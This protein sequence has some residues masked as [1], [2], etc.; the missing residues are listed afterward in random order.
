VRP[1]RKYDTTALREHTD[2]LPA[3]TRWTADQLRVLGD[4]GYEGER[5]TIAYKKPIDGELSDVETMFNKAH[6]GVRAIA[7]RGNSLLKTTFTALRNVSLCPWKS[8]GSSQPPS[9]SST[10]NTTAQHNHPQ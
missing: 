10:P 1:G 6:N 5:D 3:L 9:Y 4:L 8:A 7:E 2:I